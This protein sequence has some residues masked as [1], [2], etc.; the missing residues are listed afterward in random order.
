MR[1]GDPVQQLS[2]DKKPLYALSLTKDPFNN[3]SSSSA[4]ATGNRNISTP[5]TISCT[6]SRSI[7]KRQSTLTSHVCLVECEGAWPQER[8]TY[9][10]KYYGHKAL[11]GGALF[12][13]ENV[14]LTWSF[15]SQLWSSRSCVLTYMSVTDTKGTALSLDP[16]TQQGSPRPLTWRRW[17]HQENDRERCHFGTWC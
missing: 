8:S 10:K 1:A 12:A 5:C 13:P 2:P 14:S 9:Q 7:Y 11:M 15:G 16:K 4:I 3:S 17:I 6:P